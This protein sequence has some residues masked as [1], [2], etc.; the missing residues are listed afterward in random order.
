MCLTCDEKKTSNN[1]TSRTCFTF[2]SVPNT[3][4]PFL[5]CSSA[6]TPAQVSK[7]RQPVLLPELVHWFCHC[8]R[9]PVDKSCILT[10]LL[11]V[12][13]LEHLH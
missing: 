7:A 1:T 13:S 3:V 6:H 10:P 4:I 11:K 12:P 8:P 2:P 9:Q 5:I